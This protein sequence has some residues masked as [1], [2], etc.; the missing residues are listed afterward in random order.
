MTVTKR[1]GSKNWYMHFQLHGKTHI[2]SSR[3][4]SKKAA[5][6]MEVQ[7]KAKLHAQHFLGCRERITLQGA[8][9]QFCSSRTGTPNHPGLLSSFRC[10]SR[11]LPIQR[12]IDELSSHDLERF[13]QA[14][15]SE[16]AGSQIIKHNL[17]L[18]RGT[19]LFAKK[20]GYQVSDLEFPEVKIQ[21]KAV[22]YLSE[23]EEAHL[24]NC[25][26]PAR[27]GRGLAPVSAQPSNVRDRMQDALDLV[28]LLLDT[29]ARYSE[30]ANIEWSRINLVEKTI[31]LWRS[32]VQNQTVLFMSDR[33][34]E[35]LTRRSHKVNSPY[36]FSNM[37]GGP[38]GYAS[39]SIR[40]ALRKAGLEDCSI[41]TLRHTHASRRVQHGMSV[42]EIREILGH[43]DIKTTMRYA[44]LEANQTS[45]KARDVM[46]LLNG[47]AGNPAI[48]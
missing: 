4:T 25:L 28:I 41:H 5:E 24:L 48:G 31:N 15:I 7:W 33:V 22:R 19:W 11:L 37:T 36:I 12:P 39:I 3:T 26:D 42:Y 21:R 9:E 6:Q 38:R 44:H 14:R 43:S 16:G 27:I 47:S 46:N 40:K 2:R 45:S 10:L 29:G 32:K 23:V 34:C 13:K 8:I 17:D 20:L 18:V 1:S 30:I 35:V